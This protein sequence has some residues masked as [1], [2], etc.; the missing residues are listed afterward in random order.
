MRNKV[1]Y[2]ATFDPEV[3]VS[4]VGLCVI[5]ARMPNASFTPVDPRFYSIEYRGVHYYSVSPEYPY[6][7]LFDLR[8]LPHA[9]P[10]CVSRL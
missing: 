8:S 7:R 5:T 1:T 3:W 6:V 9:V 4:G 2:L 10:S